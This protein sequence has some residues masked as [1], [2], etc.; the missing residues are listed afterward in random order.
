M[1]LCF[2]Y[3]RNYK[4]EPLGK[5][6]LAVVGDILSIFYGDKYNL[7]CFTYDAKVNISSF[8]IITSI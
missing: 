7:Y 6:A 4:F 2:N 8:I 3:L 5:T 1:I